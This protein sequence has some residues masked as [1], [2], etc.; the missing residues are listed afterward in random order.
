MKTTR[1]WRLG[2]AALAASALL[3]TTGGVATAQSPEGLDGLDRETIERVL[4]GDEDLLQ[5]LADELGLD[6]ADLVAELQSMQAAQEEAEVEAGEAPDGEVP[7]AGLGGFIGTANG[8]ALDVGVG[9]PAELAEGIEPLLSGL[10]IRDEETGGIRIVVADTQAQLQR[11]GEGEEV[12]GLAKALVTNL[13]LDSEGSPGACEGTDTVEIPPDQDVP[14]LRI[15]VASIDCEQDDERAFASAQLAGIEISLAGLIEAGFPEEIR[16]G[17]QQPIDEFNDQLLAELNAACEPSEEGNLND[18][19]EGV[20]GEGQEACDA[21]EVQL[22]NPFDAD[23]PLAKV[24]L[25][26]ATSE[27]T[28]SDD[29]VTADATSTLEHVNVLGMACVGGDG[30]QPLTYTASASTD[31]EA[32]QQSSSA[33]DAQTRICPNEASILRLITDP[34]VFDSLK[35]V[36]N[37][38]QGVLGGNFQELFDGLEELFAALGTTAIT[39]GAPYGDVDGAGAV[40]GVSPLTIVATAPLSELPGFEET[41]LADISVSVAAMEVEA[42]VNAEPDEPVIPAEVDDP[43]EPEQDL[44]RTGASAAGL[45]GLAALGGA[46]AMRRRDQD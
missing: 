28:A 11:A 24:D 45:L 44:P 26:G 9:L 5:R 33:P 37:D 2:T 43:A 38:I 10:G 41:P 12:E 6:P 7:D 31:G 27:V 1:F 15:D 36:E 13:L 17:F 39:D 25:L 20:F 32:G 19:W 30:D 35:V 42:A 34:E 22:V 18:L 21:L 40:A 8:T 29:E 46:V 16:S 23:V 4:S 3:M 14:L